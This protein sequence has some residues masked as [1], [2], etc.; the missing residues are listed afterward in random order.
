[1]S[2]AQ[3]EQLHM[4]WPD[5]RLASP[6]AAAV[7]GGYGVRTFRPGD[8]AGYLRLMAAAGFEGFDEE[9]V[10]GY[11]TSVLPGG[12]FVVV[13]EQSGEI[14]ATAMATHAPSKLHPSGGELGWVAAS[15]GHAGNRL[16][17][18]VCA[19]VTRRLI[20][21]GYRR[22]YLRTDDWRLPAL[23]TYLNLGYRPFLFA[24]DMEPRWRAIRESLGWPFTP[25]AWP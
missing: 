12:F 13:H 10:A 17:M 9:R 16:G 21:M 11:A 5:E 15:P 18:A 20:Q 14:V 3:R 6:P 4:L 8:E 7:P 25:R 22:I 19:A 2:E 1:M 24:P 23:K